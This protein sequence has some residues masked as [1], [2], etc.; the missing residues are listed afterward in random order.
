M[1]YRPIG[2]MMI[3]EKYEDVSNK[4]VTPDT[5]GPNQSDVFV[6]KQL[7]QGVLLDDG[8]FYIP[9]IAIDDHVCIVG[10]MLKIPASSGEFLVAR[11][12]DVIAAETPASIP[13]KI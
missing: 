8:E 2:D 9:D 5:V 1:G 4:I 11:M 12:S 3:V 7:G 13:D 10:K 6:V